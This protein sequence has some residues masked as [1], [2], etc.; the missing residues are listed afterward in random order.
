LTRRLRVFGR[1]S[2]NSVIPE[3]ISARSPVL[4]ACKVR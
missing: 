3:M 2:S 4:L 1:A